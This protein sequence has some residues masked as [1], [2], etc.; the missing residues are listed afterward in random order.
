MALL[1][2]SPR[3]MFTYWELAPH[4]YAECGGRPDLVLSVDGPRGVVALGDSFG[5][6]GDRWIPA[7]EVAFLATQA[8]PMGSGLVAVEA[9]TP[10]ATPLDEV[11]R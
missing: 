6:V 3:W 7:D 2:Q 10:G 8:T 11:R 5:D 1:V 9:G 4:R